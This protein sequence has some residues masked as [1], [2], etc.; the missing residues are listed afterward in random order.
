MISGATQS[1]F[2]FL[3]QHLT[4]PDTVA[5]D[6]DPHRLANSTKPIKILWA[7]Y[8]HDQP[9]FVNV[10]WNQITHIVCVSDWQQAQFVKYL[11]IPQDKI[12][13]IRNGVA[14]YFKF[15]G[16]KEKTLIYASTPFRGLK[17]LPGIFRR[18]LKKHPDAQLRVFSGMKLYGQTD[19]A[20][21]EQIY[22]EL[23][24]TP[25]THYS[26]PVAH[27]DLAKEFGRA[28]V[29]AYPN[30]WEETSCV[31]LIEA[32]AS[33]CYPVITDIGA[34]S[35]TSMGF[36][37]VVPLTARYDSAGWI[38]DHMFLDNFADEIV[39]VLNNY[40]QID[41]QHMS[42]TVRSCHT[43]AD[44]ADEWMV[45]INQ[46]LQGKHMAKNELRI[47]K[48]AN[49]SSDKIVKDPAVLE[50]VF[51]E[52][53]RWEKEDKE[54]AQGRSN[55]QIEKFIALD[56][57]TI[58]SAFQAM[59]KNRRIMAEGLFSKITEMKE[60]QREFD[61][62]WNE[63]DRDQPL[64][65]FTKDGGKK[66]HWYDLD[67]LNLQNFLKSS[68][69]EIRDRVQ[70]IEFFDQILDK[71][72]EMN[73]GPVTRAQFE[74]EDH[75]YWERRFANQ[76]MDEML[77]RT[78]GIGIGNIHSMRRA[79]APTLVSDDVNRIK[80]PFPDLGMALSG[81]EGQMEFLIALQQKVMAGIESVTGETVGKLP[82]KSDIE[83]R[84]DRIH[85]TPPRVE[86]PQAKKN[87]VVS[88]KSLFNESL[89]NKR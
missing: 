75:V 53:F 6:Y 51:D 8:A 45:L 7:H 88:P 1:S 69:L 44:R 67:F 31:T 22:Q 47:S 64:E 26:E 28:A 57:F 56:N 86:Q 43:W 34:L 58:P 55:F 79:S 60:H 13:V 9:I 3:Q 35:E 19:T 40:N 20:E 59:L 12:T 61:Y 46:L 71:L 65:W 52:V 18:V 30:I 36:G 70:Q 21:F 49:Q 14:D 11:K 16:K 5:V 23:Q 17:Y 62:K 63:A 37:S 39:R 10:N 73:N 25:N 32:M 83:R 50:R 72:V 87:S 29:L 85:A 76:A 68:E 81:T 77:S 78:T 38:P 74:A 33:G 2:G 48:L 84:L 15:N 54:L 27:Q 4:F 42:K 89:I 82:N 80:D 24:R 66:L 41:I